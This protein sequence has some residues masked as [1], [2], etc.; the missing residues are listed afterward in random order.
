MTSAEPH[1][2]ASSV[3]DKCDPKFLRDLREASGMDVFVLARTACLSVAQVRQLESDS[4]GNLFYSLTIKR[5]AYKRLL[6]ILGAEPP[7][8][9]VPEAFRQ[10][11]QVAEAHL[12]TL[13]QIVAMSHL[14]RMQ[15]SM[16]DVLRETLDKLVAHQQVMG[17]LL[18]LLAAVLLFI[19]FGEPQSQVTAFASSIA[20]VTASPVPASS[21]A[22]A[23]ASVV[24]AAV[25]STPATGAFAATEPT[26]AVATVSTATLAK[27]AA[28]V[29]TEDELPALTSFAANKEGRFVYLVSM[30]D[31]EIC[32]VDGAKKATFLAL[33]AGEGRS[34]YG[35][36]PWQLSGAN[37]AKVQMFFQGGRVSLPDP[38]ATRV[39][40]IEVP[41]AR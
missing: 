16:G 27:T 1:E 40:L 23:S 41:V 7:T 18:M 3:Y 35:V 14:P 37:L 15:R 24:A 30:T 13:D 21:V 9:E 17:A 31:A 38:A 6:M 22:P 36:S 39:K 12:N 26:P 32:V 33:K 5:Q 4:G 29:H 11:H 10:A 34:V 19:K 20:S 25:P 28:C 2:P 8:A